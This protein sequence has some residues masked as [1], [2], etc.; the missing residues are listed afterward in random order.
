MR[1]MLIVGIAEPAEIRIEL[2]LDERILGQ[3][4]AMCVREK[5]PEPSNVPGARGNVVHEH[6]KWPVMKV[7]SPVPAIAGESAEDARRRKGYLGRPREIGVVHA[8]ETGS[9]VGK[10]PVG[11]GLARRRCVPLIAY[12]EGLGELANDR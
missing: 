6:R 2:G 3:G 10:K 7:Y 9:G 1:R 8:S 5:L 12:A 4:P 11:P